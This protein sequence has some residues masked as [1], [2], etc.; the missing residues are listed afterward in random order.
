MLSERTWTRPTHL[1]SYNICLQDVVAPAYAQLLAE[2]TLVLGQSTAYQSLWPMDQLLPQWAC[3]VPRMY[4]A[5]GGL[6]VVFTPAGAG[7]WMKPAQAVFADE[8][9]SRYGMGWLLCAHAH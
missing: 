1:R 2:A 7:Q 3:I 6:A 8:A 9:S 5:L 4:Q